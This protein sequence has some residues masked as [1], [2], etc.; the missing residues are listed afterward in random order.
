M[1]TLRKIEKPSSPDMLNLRGYPLA[2]HLVMGS[3]V[4]V[5]SAHPHAGQLS[6]TWSRLSTQEFLC[7]S[8]APSLSVAAKTSAW[9]LAAALKIFSFFPC[10]FPEI[11][12]RVRAPRGLQDLGPSLSE[13]LMSRLLFTR[14]QYTLLC[15]RHFLH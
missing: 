11:F 7:C 15:V 3:S 5:S 2:E 4:P 13:V 9:P 14:Y 1:C 6:S 12:S 10:V 8:S